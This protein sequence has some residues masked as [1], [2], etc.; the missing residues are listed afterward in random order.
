[1]LKA[2]TREMRAFRAEQVSVWDCPA[3]TLYNGRNK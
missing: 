1:M 3:A 2:I